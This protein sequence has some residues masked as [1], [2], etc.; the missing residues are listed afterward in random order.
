MS[1]NQSLVRRI[2]FPRIVG[3]GLG[4]VA[5]AS[6]FYQQQTHLMFWGLAV[7][8]AFLWPHIAYVIAKRS[9]FPRKAERRNLLEDKGDSP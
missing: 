7:V 4:F 5:V 6:V 8:Y 3:L 1:G 2:Y 9:A